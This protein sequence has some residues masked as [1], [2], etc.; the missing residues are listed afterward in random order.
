M[1]QRGPLSNIAAMPAGSKTHDI[2]VNFDAIFDHLPLGLA[3]YD[4]DSDFRC[5]RH[6][7]LFLTMLPQ[8]WHTHGAIIGTP[9]VEL[10]DEQSYRRIRSIFEQV[11][12]SGQAYHTDVQEVVTSPDGKTRFYQWSLAPLYNPEGAITALLASGSDI[13]A[14]KYAEE[15]LRTSEERFR[16]LADASFEGLIIND[17]GRHLD[18]NSA[19]GAMLGYTLEEVKQLS[20]WDFTAPE[21]HDLIREKLRTGDE[22]PYEAIAIRRDGSRFPVEIRGRNMPYQGRTVRVTSVRDI[23]EQKRIE[24][25]LR[26]KQY[27]LELALAEQKRT[28]QERLLLYH[29][30][31]QARAAAEVAHERLNFLAEATLLLS[32]SLDY[33]A[34]LRRI[35][36]LT[37]EHL[38]DWCS[39]YLID[40]A[41]VGRW[42]AALAH[43]EQ[44]QAILNA[45]HERYPPERIPRTIV[46]RV[47]NTGISGLV[48]V[49][50]DQLL[51]ETAR[52]DEHLRL[53][54]ALELRSYIAVPLYMNDQVR[55]VLAC[56]RTVGQRH[57]DTADLTLVEELARRAALAIEQARLY[58]AERE[59]RA[60]AEAAVRVR[61]VFFSIAAHELKTPLTALLGQTQLL[62][63]RDLREH[64]LDERD[65]RSI[66][67]IIG[68]GRR[69]NQLVHTLLDIKRLEHGRFSLE[70]AP[71]LLNTLIGH[72]TD[73]LRQ[74]MDRHSLLVELPDDPLVVMGDALRLEQVLQHLVDNGVKYSPGGGPIEVKLTR[75]NAYACISVR[76]RGIGIPP[77]MRPFIFERFYR[78][79]I[80][81]DR[82]ITGL[83]IGL[84]VVKEIITQ[85]GGEI[86]V[87]GAE[88]GGTIFTV[89]LPLLQ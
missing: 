51:A 75:D 65:R 85:H 53:Y 30:E 81:D 5:L 74:T 78:A 10:F 28:E 3:I 33:E 89:R 83:G 86:S 21:C 79:A 25:E 69:L 11:L 71:L 4:I 68:Q 44:H 48:P 54:R 57:Y 22:Q 14:H 12:A 37:V 58:R 56:G 8:H 26:D 77:E 36:A 39:I 76:D 18:A 34:T 62:E 43:N 2:M 55:G 80:N 6:N 87:T 45:L 46:S 24:A 84:Y 23:S 42:V 13:T 32:T 63:R 29:A 82:T 38:A 17:Q 66:S 27:Q 20:V 41:G 67:L 31:Q 72:A 50:D 59:A 35:V 88:G 19:F 7:A 52:D 73:E 47:L 60:A 61:D 9:L 15:Q 49:V 70:P 16:R 64:H 1:S 40:E